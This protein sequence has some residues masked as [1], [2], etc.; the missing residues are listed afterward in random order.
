MVTDLFWIVTIFMGVVFDR[1]LNL[2]LRVFTALLVL[3]CLRYKTVLKILKT[4]STDLQYYS[5]QIIAEYHRTGLQAVKKL[6]QLYLF[7]V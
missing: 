1:D 6:V 3:N 7:R 5:L 4:H 2:L